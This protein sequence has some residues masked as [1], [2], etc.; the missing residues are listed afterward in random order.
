[1][2]LL[3]GGGVWARLLQLLGQLYSGI[4]RQALHVVVGTV[5]PSTWIAPPTW[6]YDGVIAAMC[7]YVCFLV[8]DRLGQREIAA[9]G[10]M[11]GTPG[12]NEPESAIVSAVRQ[13]LRHC[14]AFLTGP[15]VLF[16]IVASY[17][18]LRKDYRRREAEFHINLFKVHLVSHGI[19]LTHFDDATEVRNF[20]FDRQ[21]DFK[22]NQV[23]IVRA[24]LLYLSPVFVLI[25][26]LS[27]TVLLNF[28]KDG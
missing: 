8:V 16:V 11:R 7:F 1:M 17:F 12:K 9:I 24:T 20:A 5:Y 21:A 10:S 13:V 18:V 28:P 15:L 26:A 14:L 4:F 25:S 23:A 2:S 19:S 3:Q 6:I 27:L 22:R